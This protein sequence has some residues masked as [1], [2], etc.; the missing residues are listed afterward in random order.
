MHLT[1]KSCVRHTLKLVR[2]RL[3]VSETRHTFAP[4]IQPLK[5]NFNRPDYKY[6]N[7]SKSLSLITILMDEIT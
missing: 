2:K 3:T 7:T 6:Y 1:A 4:M 5:T